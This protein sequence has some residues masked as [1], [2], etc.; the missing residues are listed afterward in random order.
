MF[1]Q[2][3]RVQF[4]DPLDNDVLAEG[5]FL[6]IAVN[7]PVEVPSSTGGMPRLADTAWVRREDG[8][9]AQVVYERIRPA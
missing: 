7:Q 3:D 2:G 5:T 6:E 8:T 9:T 4:P 1:S